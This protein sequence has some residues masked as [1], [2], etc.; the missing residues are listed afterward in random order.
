MG[1]SPVQVEGNVSEPTWKD[2]TRCSLPPHRADRNLRLACQ[3]QV[4]GD[5]TVTKYDGFWGQGETIL[6]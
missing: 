5:V 3:P 4:L 6:W 2:K 1:I